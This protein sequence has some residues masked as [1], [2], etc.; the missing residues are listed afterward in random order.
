MAADV[1]GVSGR[2]QRGSS[3]SPQEQELGEHESNFLDLSAD[4]NSTEDLGD[5]EVGL[6]VGHSRNFTLSPETTDCDSNCGDL[7]SEVSL[8]LM[9]TDMPEQSS[10]QGEP[11]SRAP[12]GKRARLALTLSTNTLNV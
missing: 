12:R 2:F 6:Q 10:A 3:R 4:S 7:D 9:E 11:A 8:L 1:R 5:T